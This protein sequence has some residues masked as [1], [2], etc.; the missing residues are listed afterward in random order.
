MG[1]K[2]PI[3]GTKTEKIQDQNSSNGTSPIVND[4]IKYGPTTEFPFKSVLLT[5][6][7]NGTIRIWVA[8]ASHAE[9]GRVLA[10]NFFP[11]LICA[12]LETESAC[13]VING[14]GA[15]MAIREN[16]IQLNK[17]AGRYQPNYA[18][19][20]QMYT[21]IS[22]QEKS[23]TQATNVSGI[24]NSSLFDSSKIKSI[25]Q[26]LSLFGHLTDYIGG[27]I[28]LAGQ[29]K[30][31]LP[32][33]FKDDF[34]NQVNS[35]IDACRQNGIKPILTTF[36]A[37]HDLSNIHKMHFSLRTNFVK[38]NTYLSPHGWIKTISEYNNVLKKI[39]NNKNIPLID[40]GS[41]LNGDYQYFIDFVHFNERGHSMAA[42]IIALELK[43][44]LN[45]EHS[46]G[47]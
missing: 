17:Y 34:E 37:S 30:D 10:K 5:P 41:K 7:K 6:E 32:L 22:D 31:S 40:I 19:L 38:Y 14:S 42:S 47:F 44:I 23:L 18:I 4:V 2:T 43:R 12:N 46:S 11:N 8:S 33:S 36:A 24:P 20:Y 3:F 39:A 16:I 29:L 9:G 1:F 26:S 25:F 21:A 15:G 27:N 35:F 28:K 45:E 13:E